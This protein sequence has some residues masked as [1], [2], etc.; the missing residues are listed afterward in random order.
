PLQRQNDIMRLLGERKE[1]TVKELCAELFYSEATV[2]RDLTALEKK[3]LLK[4]SFGG[5][6]LTESF[7]EQLPLFIR[8][9]KN[10][11]EKKHI[12]AKAAEYIKEGDTVFVDASTTTYFIAPYLKNIPNITV[13]TN[14][15]M[16]CVALSEMK[17]HNH[18]T[19]G[20]MLLDSVALAGSDTERFIRNIRADVCLI[21]AR[22]LAKNGEI[23]DSSKA[24]RDVKLAM[25]ERSARRYFLCDLSKDGL[26]FQYKV[27]DASDFDEVIRG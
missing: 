6:V 17:I 3:G 13:I 25:I 27:G 1:M 15:P 26:V 14:N 11:P 7:S 20:E 22:G 23:T 2:R 24:E 5:A 8:A 16:L 21:S 19:G 9:A 12:C 10:V 4:R 18:C